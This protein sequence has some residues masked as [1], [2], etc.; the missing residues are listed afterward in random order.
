MNVGNRLHYFSTHHK[1]V[2]HNL[3]LLGMHCVRRYYDITPEGRGGEFG[4]SG[5]KWAKWAKVGKSWLKWAKGEGGK[6]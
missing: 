6:G 5:Q 4:K 3:F 2:K 1:N